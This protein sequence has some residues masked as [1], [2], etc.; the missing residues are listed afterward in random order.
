MLGFF[1][2][3]SRPMMDTLQATGAIQF[4]TAV[5]AKR[6]DLRRRR[7]ALNHRG[8]MSEHSVEAVSAYLQRLTP[9]IRTPRGNDRGFARCQNPNNFPA[10]LDSATTKPQ[11]PPRPIKSVQEGLDHSWDALVIGQ[12]FGTSLRTCKRETTP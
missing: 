8:P 7:R 1:H 4:A 9:A 3:P 10:N 5:K 12:T 11:K 2:P 6:A